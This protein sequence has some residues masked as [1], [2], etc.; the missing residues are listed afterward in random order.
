MRTD[1]LRIPK[2]RRHKRVGPAP[3][4][5][6]GTLAKRENARQPRLQLAT[7]GVEHCRR[8]A[9]DPSEL[10][11]ALAPAPGE[12]RWLD[13]QGLGD[14]DLLRRIADVLGLHPLTLEDIVHTH[15]RPKVEEFD[16]HLFVV[17][18]A[19]RLGEENHV[20]NEQIS[21][22]IEDGLIV[23]FQEMYGD[24][25]DPV[26]KRLDSGKGRIREAGADYLAWALIDAVIDNYFPVLEAYGGI[27]DQLDDAIRENPTIEL[28]KA[29]HSMR[30]ELRVFRRATWPFRDVVGVLGR[31]DI[32]QID[33]TVR[34]SFR[35]CYD[36]VVQVSDFVEGARERA[37]ELADLHLVMVGERTNQV[38]KVLTIIATIFIPLTFL[39]GLYGMNFDPEASPY[40]MPELKWRF[41]YPAFWGVML[42]VFGLML[43]FFR[44]KGWIGGSG[45]RPNQTPE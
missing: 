17:L 21:M 29:I 43:W 37:S 20:E 39:C 7:Y 40:N 31:N 12:T 14:H 11:Q 19:I 42:L 34:P 44:R 30:R 22:V 9:L 35:D 28:S 6:P 10:E 15:Q 24:G 27:M 26:R 3:G 25:Y 18:R 38:M 4:A 45:P 16:D 23:T 2:I 5:A 36:H 41:G 1:L 32:D 8:G 13:V 33:Q